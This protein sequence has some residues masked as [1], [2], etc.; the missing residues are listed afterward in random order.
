MLFPIYGRR[1]GV[2]LAL[3]L[4]PLEVARVD[5]KREL[6]LFSAYCAHTSYIGEI[7]LDFSPEGRPSRDQQE[8]ALAAI[9]AAPGVPHK[10]L[11]VHSRGAAREVVATL[12]AAGTSRVILHWFSGPTR[13]L[14]SAVDAGFYFSVNPAMTWSVRGQAIVKRLPPDRVL[15]ESDG[16]YV[17]IGRRELEP[18]DVV[19]VLDHLAKSWRIG[20]EEVAARLAIN[21]RRLVS[22]DTTLVPRS[23][24]A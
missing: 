9:L 14:D 21:L 10:I 22:E 4:H 2:R 16:P 23:P 1:D 15:L 19:L 12:A 13:D 5:L 17:R 24:G 8:E 18:R 6:A 11:S 3:G 20:R 7:G